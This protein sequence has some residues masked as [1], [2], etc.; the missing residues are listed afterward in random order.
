VK[1]LEDQMSIY[2]AYHQDARN[3]AT[4]F[5]GVPVIVFSL[6]I[7][8][9]WLRVHHMEVTDERVQTDTYVACG[10]VAEMVTDMLDVFVRDFL[11]ERMEEMVSR[12]LVNGY[13]PRLGLA[14]GQRFASKGGYLVHFVSPT[15]N[16]IAADGDWIVP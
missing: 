13:Y 5:V 4:H 11:V 14:P 10:I 15:A 12:R 8:L 1:T 7:P 2:A 9:G 3:K 6:L 16:A